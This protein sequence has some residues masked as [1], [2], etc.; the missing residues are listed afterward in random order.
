M[1]ILTLFDT[2]HSYSVAKIGEPTVMEQTTLVPILEILLKMKIL[3]VD[4]SSL[5]AESARDLPELTPKT[6]LT[7]C[8][9]YSK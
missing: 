3:R 7:L 8:L 9:R 4:V 6:T 2:S 1:A 5:D